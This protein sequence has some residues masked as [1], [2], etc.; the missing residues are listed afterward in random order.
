MNLKH[1]TTNGY[2][3]VSKQEFHQG[4]LQI[5][6]DLTVGK[7][8]TILNFASLY[9]VKKKNVKKFS[10]VLHQNRNQILPLVN[11]EP[12][13]EQARAFL[14]TIKDMMLADADLQKDF[15]ASLQGSVN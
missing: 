2:S 10:E 15:T 6:M 3:I 12:S 7:G 5:Q 11:R 4:Y 8:D 13:Q 9:G 14:L 1:I